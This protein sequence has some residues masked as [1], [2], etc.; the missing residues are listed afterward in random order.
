MPIQIVR[1]DFKLNQIDNLTAPTRLVP[2]D[3]GGARVTCDADFQVHVF[4]SINLP[5]GD[6][7]GQVVVGQ[8]PAADSL[9]NLDLRSSL[10]YVPVG[11]TVNEISLGCRAAHATEAVIVRA[12]IP[13]VKKKDGAVSVTLMVI[14]EPGA[15]VNM[16]MEAS[17]QVTPVPP[18]HP[19]LPPISP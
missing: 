12:T 9:P 10:F 15:K 4:A 16:E 17:G 5:P 6:Y 13:N 11:A 8:A 18:H 14:T 7:T 19:P 2:L 1:Q 3:G